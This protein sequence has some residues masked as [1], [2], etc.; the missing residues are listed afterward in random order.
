MRHVC[1]FVRVRTTLLAVSVIAVA[2]PHGAGAQGF[3]LNE[4]GSCALARA[5]ANTGAP[6]LDGSIIFWNPAAATLLAGWNVT[7]GAAPIVSRGNFVADT[8]ERRWNTH[9]PTRI[10]PQAAVNYHKTGTKA[11]FGIAAYA[12][13][14]LMT[15]WPGDFVGRFV[16]LKASLT[17]V[18][19]QPNVAWMIGRRWSIGGGPVFGFSSLE[20]NRAIDLSEQTASPGVTFGQLGIP[21]FTEFARADL[22]GDANAV[23]I[24]LAVYGRLARSWTAGARFLGPMTFN[25]SGGEATFTQVAT[26]LVFGAALQSPPS[27]FVAG[28]KIDNIVAAQFLPPGRLVDQSVSTRIVHPAQAE[29]GVGYSG[30]KNWSFSADYSWVG[31]SRFNVVP[32]DFADTSLSET[33]IE[34]Y[35]NAGAIRLGAEYTAPSKAWQ[36]RAGLAASMSAAPAETVT[37]LLPEQD[38]SYYTVGAGIPFKRRW[39]IDLAY[40]YIATPGSRGRVVER[41]SA[42]QTAAELNTGV[43]HAWASIF[44]LTLKVDF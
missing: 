25:Y 44:S 4:I 40:A 7:L 39:T 10:V 14:G 28:A 41:T 35:R 32:L 19:V 23:G 13:Y 9:S 24:H 36:G 17:T 43:Y 16:S 15:E 3:G 8:I 6:C 38:R 21:R 20:L 34:A 18:Y 29:V 22:R 26:N 31:W 11:A 1:R 42:A 27:P 2:A 30:V 37:P 12:P 33:L 5:F